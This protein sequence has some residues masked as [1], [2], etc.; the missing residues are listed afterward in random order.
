MNTTQDNT[1][2]LILQLRKRKKVLPYSDN[3]T[4]YNYI[5]THYKCTKV[6][7]KNI[8]SSYISEIVMPNLSNYGFQNEWCSFIGCHKIFDF[9][10]ELFPD[11]FQLMCYAFRNF[12]NKIYYYKVFNHDL[13]Y[14]RNVDTYVFNT[15]MNFKY[16]RIKRIIG[17]GGNSIVLNGSNNSVIKIFFAHAS[18]Y[19]T[20]IL[21]ICNNY[22][23]FPNIYYWNDKFVIEEKLKLHTDKCKKYIDLI[24]KD[25]A[26]SYYYKIK[27]NRNICN[28]I[29]FD[30]EDKKII[31]WGLTIFNCN[32]RQ[33]YNDIYDIILDNIGERENG[34]IVL[35]DP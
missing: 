14:I 7:L 35:F 10:H 8:F 29:K 22:D 2:N 33:K 1:T 13:N 15:I 4:V 24:C 3:F 12:I 32:A 17:C 5:H 9:I 23:C 19:T 6:E 20:N 11:N 25:N 26:D 34:D 28:E 27:N 21:K 31:E 30:N 18:E 16:R